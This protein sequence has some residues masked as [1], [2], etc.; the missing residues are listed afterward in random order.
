MLARVEVRRSSVFLFA[1]GRF[2]KGMRGRDTAAMQVD[3]T[4]RALL[5][6]AAVGVVVALFA[7]AAAFVSPALTRYVESAAFRA[8]LEKETAKG[9]HFPETTF[10]PVRRSGFLTATS[11]LASARNGRKAMTVIEA[12]DITASFNPAGIFLRRW[13]IDD[14]HVERATIGI[15][16]YEPKP[17]PSPA[18]PWYAVFLPDRVYLNHVWSDH[19]DITWRMR[20]QRAGI[21]DTHL[22]I[23]PYGRDFNYSASGGVLRNPPLPELQLEQTRLLI[24]KTVFTLYNLDVTSGKTGRVH[25]EGSAAT[26]GNKNLDFRFSW[27]RLAI[28]QWLP[29]SWSDHV[30]GLAGGEMRWN[31][32]DYKLSSGAFTGAFRVDE[33]K[34]QNLAVLD[35]VAAVTARPDLRTLEL[36]R[37]AARFSWQ[38]SEYHLSDIELEQARKFRIAGNISVRDGTLAGELELAVARPYLTWLPRPEEVFPRESGGYLR[39]T[40]HLSGTLQKPQQDLSPRI[41]EN[42]KGSPSALIGAALRQLGLLLHGD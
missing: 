18:K 34:I 36:S 1:L 38:Q 24:T 28:G 15:Q 37:C 35:Q 32:D 23:T 12:H 26:R 39:T 13:S 22:V 30:G 33:G 25:V 2:C 19:A 6:A 16:V 17:E 31:G 8:E 10:A 42:L 41:W 27:N 3:G 9:L 20:G 11:S 29:S 4:K 14:L 5:I 21:F 40:V 7:A